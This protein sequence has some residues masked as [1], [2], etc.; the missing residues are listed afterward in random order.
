MTTSSSL[1]LIIFAKFL[2]KTCMNTRYRSTQNDMVAKWPKFLT[3]CDISNFCTFFASANQSLNQIQ[4]NMKYPDSM[5]FLANTYLHITDMGLVQYIVIGA[6]IFLVVVVPICMTVIVAKCFM[7]TKVRV[8]P[9]MPAVDDGSEQDE[10]WSFQMSS[11]VV[12][13]P[14]SASSSLARRYG[15]DPLKR[16]DQIHEESIYYSVDENSLD[17]QYKSSMLPTMRL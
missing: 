17:Y 7:K 11:T 10:A 1:S 2:S 14:H 15:T 12:A 9:M 4:P 6:G 16:K 8:M 3:R 5:H 13:A